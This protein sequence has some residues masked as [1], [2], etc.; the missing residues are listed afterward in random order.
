MYIFIFGTPIPFN[1]KMLSRITHFHVKYVLISDCIHIRLLLGGI[2][3]ILYKNIETLLKSLLQ[4]LM[5]TQSPHN[6][7]LL[8]RF[9]KALRGKERQ[10]SFTISHWYAHSLTTQ[11]NR[12][13]RKSDMKNVTWQS[14]YIYTSKAFPAASVMLGM[15]SD[16]LYVCYATRVIRARYTVHEQKTHCVPILLLV[17]GTFESEHT[18]RKISTIHRFK[19]NKIISFFNYTLK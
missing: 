1:H 8:L 3:A 17:F 13:E 19:K 12:R 4:F 5:Q 7:S 14:D 15:G 16:W 6:S 9:L 2:H 10:S 11:E 18:G